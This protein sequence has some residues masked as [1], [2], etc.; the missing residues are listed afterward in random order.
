MNKSESFFSQ[1]KNLI[2]VIIASM[3]LRLFLTRT[4]NI[5]NIIMNTAYLG[6]FVFTLLGKKNKKLRSVGKYYLFTMLGLSFINNISIFK[7]Y[8]LSKNMNILQ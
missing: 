8:I 1:T 5:L 4:I 7:V 2:I 6:F 3:V